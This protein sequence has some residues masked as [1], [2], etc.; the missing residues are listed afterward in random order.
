MAYSARFAN[1]AFLV[2]SRWVVEIDGAVGDV[3]RAVEGL[4]V[5][6][7]GYNGIGRNEAG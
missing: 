2:M 3:G 5:G 7:V 1:S 4:G 6:E